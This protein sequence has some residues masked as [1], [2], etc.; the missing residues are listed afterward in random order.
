M[1]IAYLLCMGY[2]YGRIIP[3]ERGYRQLSRYQQ[4]LLSVR[5]IT[6]SRMETPFK[7]S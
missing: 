6:A 2:C 4:K 3:I 1:P 7:A 5:L